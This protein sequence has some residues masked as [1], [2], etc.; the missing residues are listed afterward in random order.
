MRGE[1]ETAK[2]RAPVRR[3]R[4][5][6]YPEIGGADALPSNSRA[7]QAGEKTWETEIDGVPWTHDAPLPHP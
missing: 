1:Y 6:V 7:V 4:L 2:T 5:T 3:C